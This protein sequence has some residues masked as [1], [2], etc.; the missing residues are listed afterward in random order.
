MFPA[1]F[2]R[3]SVPTSSV[4]SGDG[5][6]EHLELHILWSPSDRPDCCCT[7][8]ASLLRPLALLT[9]WNANLFAIFIW[10]TKCLFSYSTLETAYTVIKAM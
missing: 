3:V 5:G 6:G 4:I 8:V 9:E 10:N 1:C 2:P 7:S